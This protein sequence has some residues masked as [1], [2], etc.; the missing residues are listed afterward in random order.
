MSEIDL[1]RA[2]RECERASRATTDPYVRSILDAL[3]N[4]WIEL[5]DESSFLDPD[6]LATQVLIVSSIQAHFT[7]PTG[8]TLH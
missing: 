8:Q 4:L 6:D 2:A 3:R 7:A 1:W 5:D